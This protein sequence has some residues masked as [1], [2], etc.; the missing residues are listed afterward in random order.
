LLLLK[1][2]DAYHC[3]FLRLDDLFEDGGRRWDS[4]EII[5]ERVAEI[6]VASAFI[7]LVRNMS[8]EGIYRL[9]I[10]LYIARM[11]G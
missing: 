7:V 3:Y 8:T 2:K 11:Q 6:V 4:F 9:S 10:T 1:A 5:S